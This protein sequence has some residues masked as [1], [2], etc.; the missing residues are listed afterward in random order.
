MVGRSTCASECDLSVR[1]SCKSSF[2]RRV[3]HRIDRLTKSE[4]HD[5][6]PAQQLSLAQRGS[7]NRGPQ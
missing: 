4:P 2:D 1:R 3:G 7:V 6:Q 5:V